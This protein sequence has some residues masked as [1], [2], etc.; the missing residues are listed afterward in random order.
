MSSIWKN[1]FKL[2]VCGIPAAAAIHSYIVRKL[3]RLYRRLLRECR[4]DGGAI[5]LTRARKQIQSWQDS[6]GLFDSISREE[7]DRLYRR[8]AD[9]HAE[10]AAVEIRILRETDDEGED[11]FEEVSDRREEDN[12]EPHRS[13]RRGRHRGAARQVCDGVVAKLGRLPYSAAQQLVV[14]NVAR[15]LLVEMRVRNRDLA[16]LLPQVVQDYFTPTEDDYRLAATI[17]SARQAADRREIDV[18]S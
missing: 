2:A 12:E 16:K 8:I 6:R 1:V 3:G 7:G 11:P 5:S 18:K 4:E 10:E 9:Q 17:R 14:Q 13:V 15:T